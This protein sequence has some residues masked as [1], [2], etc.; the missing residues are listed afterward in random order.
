MA[1]LP[2]ICCLTLAS[3][4]QRLQGSGTLTLQDSEDWLSTR[5]LK[6]EKLTLADLLSEGAAML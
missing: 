2:T 5:S 1:T 3:I 6:Y 4:S